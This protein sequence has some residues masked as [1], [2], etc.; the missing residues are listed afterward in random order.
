MG[1]LDAL[2]LVVTHLILRLVSL[3]K[4]VHHDCLHFRD[5]ETE[6]EVTCMKSNRLACLAPGAVVRFK[7]DNVY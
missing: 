4:S 7:R 5:T 3:M 6:A 2:Q 1:L